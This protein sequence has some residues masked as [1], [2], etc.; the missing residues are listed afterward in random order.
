MRSTALKAVALA[1]CS[2]LFFTLTYVL[3]RAVVSGGVQRIL[4]CTR[5]I[6]SGKVKKSA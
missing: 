3:N 4:A 1:L 5:C 2:A 6:R